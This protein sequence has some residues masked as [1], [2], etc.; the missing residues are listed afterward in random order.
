MFNV[1]VREK[2]GHLKK[3]ID[4]SPYLHIGAFNSP[5]YTAP[6]RPYRKNC[7]VD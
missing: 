4:T 2:H 1:Q 3:F 7:G 6:G 5:F